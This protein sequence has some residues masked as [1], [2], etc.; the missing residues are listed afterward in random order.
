M[1]FY[2]Q[3]SPPIDKVLYER[4]FKD[5]KNGTCLEA[6]AV[7][8]IRLSSTKVFEEFLDW[9][10]I[11]V[12]PHP[13]SFKSLVENRPKAIN[14]NCALSDEDSTALFRYGPNYILRASLVDEKGGRKR[15]KFEYT[16]VQT[17]TYKSIIKEHKIDHLDLMVLDVEGHE[18]KAIKGM[19]GSNVLPRVLCIEVNHCGIDTISPLLLELGYKHDH[20]SKIN[21]I[22]LKT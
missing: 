17:K 3:F 16:E 9:N 8:G 10:C 18:E 6:G 2:G 14:I 5:K 21:S 13:N 7:D 1:K 11:N 19:I 15:H 12:E 4:Y 20:N 22:F